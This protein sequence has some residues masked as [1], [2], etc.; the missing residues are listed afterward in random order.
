MKIGKKKHKLIFNATPLNYF[1]V[2]DPPRMTSL[3]PELVSDHTDH[4]SAYL[5]CQVDSSPA[6]QVSNCVSFL[7]HGMSRVSNYGKIRVA[8][9]PFKNG[10]IS[11]ALWPFFKHGKMRV[12]LWPF[13][14]HGKSRDAL[15]PFLNIDK[16]EVGL[17]QE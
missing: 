15:W 16:I 11:V 3:S 2:A 10:K 14:I 17:W 7:N 8:L 4:R 5:R 1:D 6:S 9:L 13:F 12:A